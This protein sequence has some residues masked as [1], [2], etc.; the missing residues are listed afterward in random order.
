MTFQ[1]ILVNDMNI[2]NILKSIQIHKLSQELWGT[3]PAWRRSKELTPLYVRRYLGPHTGEIAASHPFWELAYIS[4]GKGQLYTPD[5]HEY[6]PGSVTLIPP[7][8]DHREYAQTMMEVIW[9]AMA[10]TRLDLLPKK[11]ILEGRWP[12]I[13][14]QV[15]RLWLLAEHARGRVGPELDGLTEALLARVLR[16]AEEAPEPTSR[17]IQQVVEWLQKH[18]D[19]PISIADLAEDFGYSEGYFFRAFRRYTGQSPAAYLTAIRMQH[20][21]QIMQ[22]TTLTFDRIARIVGYQDPLYF[23]RLFRKTYSQSPS[24]YR[25]LLWSGKTHP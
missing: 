17:R 8:I 14:P 22:R 19:Q 2:D 5:R 4:R 3:D 12:E 6:Q 21:V 18:F 15:E 23:S 11:D 9:I 13:E 7:D 1:V 25:K 24:A 20:A 16:L 10:G